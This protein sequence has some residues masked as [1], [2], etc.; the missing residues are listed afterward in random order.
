MYAWVCVYFPIPCKQELLSLLLTCWSQQWVIIIDVQ[1]LKHGPTVSKGMWHTMIHTYQPIN[2]QTLWMSMAA[3]SLACFP[4]FLPPR[5]AA[6]VSPCNCHGRQEVKQTVV[7]KAFRGVACIQQQL[8]SLTPGSTALVYKVNMIKGHA[9][10][11]LNHCSTK[12]IA[13][14]REIGTL[15][16][17][18][19]AWI[20]KRPL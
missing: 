2:D 12:T 17:L 16:C 6:I 15:Y 14:K 20:A 10:W 5:C 3:S 4:Y 1:V 7:D 13:S 18:T 9:C 11:P 8:P 19:A